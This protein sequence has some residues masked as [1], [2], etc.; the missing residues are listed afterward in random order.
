VLPKGRRLLLLGL[1]LLLGLL[2]GWLLQ[3]VRRLLEGVL[4]LLLLGL[5]LLLLLRQLVLLRL[6]LLMLLGELLRRASKGGRRKACWLLLVGCRLPKLWAGRCASAR[7]ATWWASSKAASSVGGGKG[8]LGW[9]RGASAW[10]R[11]PGRL[12]PW[13]G[14]KA[15]RRLRRVASWRAILGLSTV[16][17]R[18]HWQGRCGRGVEV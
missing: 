17:V 12:G 16:L 15:A 14:C 9:Q 3:V 4:L 2:L 7:D 6:L 10:K 5:L 1:V 11:A 13:R 18:L 8:V